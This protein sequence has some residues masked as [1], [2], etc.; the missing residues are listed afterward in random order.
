MWLIL[1]HVVLKNFKALKMQ[2]NPYD[3]GD[4]KSHRVGI[5]WDIKQKKWRITVGCPQ[6]VFF[7]NDIQKGLDYLK[8]YYKDPLMFVEN[9]KLNLGNRN[10]N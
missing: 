8:E 7:F 10:L 6:Y 5:K 2:N 9:Y 4:S 1:V 3:L